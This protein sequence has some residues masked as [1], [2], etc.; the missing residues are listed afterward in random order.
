LNKNGKRA[1][2]LGL[3]RYQLYDLVADPKEQNNLYEKKPE[4]AAELTRLLRRYVDRGRFTAGKTQKN[5]G[6]QYW[7]LLPWQ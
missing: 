5:E 6:P 7:N 1:L 3:P 2:K 4:V